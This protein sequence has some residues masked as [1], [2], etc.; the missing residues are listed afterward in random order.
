MP[1]K[2][3]SGF[4][5]ILVA[6]LI[7]VLTAGALGGIYYYAEIYQPKQYAQEAILIHK[8]FQVGLV[9]IGSSPFVPAQS[10]SDI[11]QIAQ[12]HKDVVE[13]T[14]EKLNKLKPPRKMKQIHGDFLRLLDTLN[15][16][17]SEMTALASSIESSLA[18]GRPDK[19]FEDIQRNLE[20]IQEE[21]QRR[22]NLVEQE[23]IQLKELY[24]R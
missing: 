11:L 15:T 3:I 17:T 24:G 20:D 18:V 10:P 14:R 19:S 13:K 8:D 6:V 5:T 9:K 12:R 1:K 23:F 16:F 22:A 21:V 7:V 4:A 2:T